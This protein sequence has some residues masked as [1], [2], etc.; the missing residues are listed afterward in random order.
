MSYTEDVLLNVLKK[1][2]GELEFHQAV[3]EVFSSIEAVFEKHPEYE[4]AG[5]LERLV[6]PE[7]GDAILAIP[8]LLTSK[9]MSSIFIALSI[10]DAPFPV[11]GILLLY[12]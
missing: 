4:E 10:I 9:L 3:R 7:R 11:Y 12:D 6:E 8:S 2:P 1:N 5:I